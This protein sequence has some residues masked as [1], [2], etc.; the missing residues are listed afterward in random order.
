M[1]KPA[2]PFVLWQQMVAGQ[3]Y[4][5]TSGNTVDELLPEIST[6]DWFITGG[7]VE[8]GVIQRRASPKKGEGKKAAK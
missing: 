4:Q 3:G 7:P 5:P 2:G 8:I 1:T 6:K